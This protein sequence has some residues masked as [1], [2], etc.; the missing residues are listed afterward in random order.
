MK[1]HPGML[2]AFLRGEGKLDTDIKYVLLCLGLYDH[3]SRNITYLKEIQWLLPKCD[4][5]KVWKRS[6]TNSQK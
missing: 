4:E 5:G 2:L 6:I 3:N 1:D